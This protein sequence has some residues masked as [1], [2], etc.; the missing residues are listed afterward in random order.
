[1]ILRSGCKKFASKSHNTVEFFLVDDGREHG[2]LF[3]ELEYDE[4]SVNL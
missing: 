4:E 1:M 2:I 3:N